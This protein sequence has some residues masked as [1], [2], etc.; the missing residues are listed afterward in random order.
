MIKKY[1]TKDFYKVGF[2]KQSRASAITYFIVTIIAFTLLTAPFIFYNIT[3]FYKAF[4]SELNNLPGQLNITYKKDEGLTTNLKAPA[5]MDLPYFKL[6]VDPYS[7]Y[8]PNDKNKE[9]VVLRNKGILVYENNRVTTQRTYKSF[10]MEDLSFSVGEVKKLVNSLDLESKL[11]ILAVIIFVGSFMRALI[12]GI[13]VSFVFALV[14]YNV[15]RNKKETTYLQTVK[16]FIYLLPIYFIGLTLSVF[17]FGTLTGLGIVSLAI[18][19]FVVK[20]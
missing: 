14:P 9:V 7:M 5:V 17:T 12:T 4:A 18:A 1:F 11:P 2:K 15:Q 10:E 8:T 20:S 3:A 16:L 19:Y 13:F 6:V